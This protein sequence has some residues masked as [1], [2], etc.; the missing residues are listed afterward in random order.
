MKII[1][2]QP[3]GAVGYGERQSARSGKVWFLGAGPGDPELLTLRAVAPDE[4]C[5]ERFPVKVENGFVYLRI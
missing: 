2:K 3:R 4:G 1:T 5:T